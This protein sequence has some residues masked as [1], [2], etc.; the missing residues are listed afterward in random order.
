MLADGVGRQAGVVVPDPLEELLLREALAGVGREVGQ[1]LHLPLR[2]VDLL[3]AE[4][5]L[6]RDEVEVQRREVDAHRLGQPVAT[7]LGVDAGEQDVEAERLG[8]V[9]VAA[10]AEAANDRTVLGEG[11]DEDDRCSHRLAQFGAQV[12]AGTVGQQHVE[13]QQVGLV[14]PDDGSRLGDGARPQDLEAVLVE[15]ACHDFEKLLL[16]LD[17]KDQGTPSRRRAH[18]LRTSCDQSSDP[19]ASLAVI[20]HCVAQPIIPWPRPPGARK[21]R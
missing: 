4:D 2:Q 11:R 8:D 20:N 15:V 5:H 3:V 21:R 7:E 14:F 19:C 10:G 16:I 6:A 9:V 18:S 12:V 13:Q 17:D 1:Q